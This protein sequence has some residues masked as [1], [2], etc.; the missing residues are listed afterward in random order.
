VR[1]LAVALCLVLSQLGCGQRSQYACTASNECV[2]NGI[3]GL[4]EPQG[5]CAFPDPMCPSGD[6]FETN[7]GEGLGGQCVPP[8]TG[9]DSGIDTMIDAMPTNCGAV[10]MACCPN[11]TCF[12]NGFCDSGMCKQCVTD[13]GLG[14][15]HLCTLKYDGSVWCSGANDK[16]QLGT[17]PANAA[18]GTLTR[19]APVKDTSNAVIMDATAIAAGEGHTCV[20]RTGGTVWCWGRND[21]GQ[22]GPT[23]TSNG[24]AVQITLASDMSPLTGIVSI[25]AGHDQVYA[26]DGTGTAWAWGESTNGQLGDGMKVNRPRAAPVLVAAA[27][28]NFP[29]VAAISTNDENTT[30]LRD[31]SNAIYCWGGNADGTVGDNTVVDKTSPVLILSGVDVAVGRRHTCAVKTDNTV[32]CWGSSGHLRLATDTGEVHVPTQSLSMPGVPFGGVASL[33]AAGVSCAIMLNGDLQCWGANVHGQVGTG[34]TAYYP[35]PV[36]RADGTPLH[37]VTKVIANYSHTCAMLADGEALC[38]GNNGSGEFGDGTRTN[39]NYP[40][41]VPLTCP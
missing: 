29:N 34:M 13:I 20:I 1:G 39:R 11:S 33:A 41:P 32:A 2:L 36:V 12:G 16:A 31:T 22:T 9:I 25:A 5:F 6:R 24:A 18:T 37:N 17:G 27:G 14:G 30:C 40:G 28:A 10:G 23:G 8:G 7:A 19:G 21:D 3:D 35:M 15:S 26:I 38:W 4:C